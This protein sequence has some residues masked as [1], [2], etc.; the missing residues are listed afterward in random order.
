MTDGR[1]DGRTAAAGLMR[2]ISEMTLV[3]FA[4]TARDGEAFSTHFCSKPN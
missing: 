1:M 3:L 2:A 4:D